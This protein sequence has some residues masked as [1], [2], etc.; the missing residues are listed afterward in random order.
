MATVVIAA[1]I[2]DR[3]T[4]VSG[5]AG[6]RLH[7]IIQER[8]PQHKSV[9]IP[10]DKA[11]HECTNI[12]QKYAAEGSVLF[13]YYGHGK[14]K[15]LC[16]MIPPH[17][18]TGMGGMVDPD[19]VDV[20]KGI[21]CH[22]TACWSAVKLGRLAEEIGVKAFVGSRAPCHVAFEFSEHDYKKS[23]IDVWMS[24]PITMLQGGTVAD[25]I[26]A[27][28]EKSREYEALYEKM[29]GE[30]TYSDYYLTRFRKNIDILV[31]FGLLTSTII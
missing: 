12:L 14:P 5:A 18:G 1:P 27:M 17:C 29:V 30:W 4:G 23:L 16:G 28:D 2:N 13:E 20:L 19:N 15:K 6:R 3:P 7:E 21:V 11:I 25:A 10:D 31:P 8:F 26:R 9:F 24:F 22:A